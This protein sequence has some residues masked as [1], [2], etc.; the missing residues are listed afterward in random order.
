MHASVAPDQPVDHPADHSAVQ[1]PT[2]ETGRA[3]AGPIRHQVPVRRWF[4]LWDAY[5]GLSYLVTTGL[6][7][8]SGDAPGRVA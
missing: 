5:F 1:S 4:G 8:T 7:L 3:P 6:L 2:V